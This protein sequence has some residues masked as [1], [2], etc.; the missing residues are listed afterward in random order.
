MHEPGIGPE[1]DL[2]ARLELMPLA[3]HRDHLL[4]AEP[5]D[6]LGFR[7]GRLDHLDLGLDAVLVAAFRDGEMLGPDAADHGAAGPR[8][9]RADRQTQAARPFEL[10]RAV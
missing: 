8:G 9:R 10:R 2:V 1:P 6:D 4:A 5:G 3:K 7:A